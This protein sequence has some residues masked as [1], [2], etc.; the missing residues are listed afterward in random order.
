MCGHDV[1]LKVKTY[2]TDGLH[3]GPLAKAGDSV[4]WL[5]GMGLSYDFNYPDVRLDARTSGHALQ[6]PICTEF[7]FGAFFM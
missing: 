2:A 5:S 1:M 6:P 4:A 3:I 7:C